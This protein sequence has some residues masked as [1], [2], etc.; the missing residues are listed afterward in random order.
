MTY[1]TTSN[2]FPLIDAAQKMHLVTASLA[3]HLNDIPKS[4]LQMPY[5]E[6]FRWDHSLLGTAQKIASK[7]SETIAALQ[8]IPQMTVNHALLEQ[9]AKMTAIM[10]SLH[11]SIAA[12][13]IKA[14]L[15]T[16]EAMRNIPVE[17][18][19]HLLTVWRPSC[20]L[21]AFPDNAPS[22]VPPLTP[23]VAVKHT[24]R[25]PRKRQIRKAAKKEFLSMSNDVLCYLHQSAPDVLESTK[26]FFQSAQ[27]ECFFFVLSGGKDSLTSCLSMEEKEVF[28]FIWFIS[29]VLI[30]LFKYRR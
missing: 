21:F 26:K 22:V 25:H 17:Q 8:R 11:T 24:S 3:K 2:L 19:R 10:Q 27:F 4:L 9:S 16:S 23:S 7:Q 30:A 18:M 15:E 6:P 20:G 28:D 1:A 13:G 12:S 5:I 29:I 14:A